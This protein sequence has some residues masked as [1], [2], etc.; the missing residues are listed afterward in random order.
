MGFASAV[1]VK[2]QNKTAIGALMSG[3]LNVFS[4]SGISRSVKMVAA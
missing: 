3:S 1:Y 4:G 2:G